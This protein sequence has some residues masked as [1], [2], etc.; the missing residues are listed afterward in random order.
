MLQKIRDNAHGWWTWLLVPILIILFAFWGIGNYLGGS[1][2]Q[3]EVAKVNGQSISAT[4]FMSM[5]QSLSNSNNPSQNPQLNQEIKIQVLQALVSKTLLAQALE[6]LGFAVDDPS[7]NQMIYHIPAFQ[8]NGQFSLQLYQAFLQNIGESTASLKTDLRQTYLINQFQN[9]LMMTGLVLPNEIMTETNYANMFRTVAYARV[10][11]SN[12]TSQTPITSAQVQAY[13]NAHQ[14]SFT[15]PLQVRLSYVTLSLSQ[16]S[17]KGVD[18]STAQANYSAALNQ[19]ANL[20]FQNSSSLT[21]LAQAFG[22]NVQTTS[23]Q[24][25]SKPTGILTNANVIAAVSSDSVLAQGNNSGVINLSPTQAVV[26]RVIS[27]IPSSPLPLVTVQKQIVAQ[28]K[29][30]ATTQNAMATLNSM[31]DAINQ[32]GSLAQVAPAYG[33]TVETMN[34]INPKSKVLPA[35]VINAALSMGVNQ[36]AAI[37]V[38]NGI[39]MVIEVTNVYPNPKAAKNPISAEALQGLW[40]Q[41]EL[42]QYL[43]YLQAQA[44]VNI[45]QALF[46]PS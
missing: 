24:D 4:E 25:T 2:S 21:P 39:V 35:A 6:K 3:D 41:I 30:Q 1:F 20:A 32:G 40:T 12:F 43:A 45:N 19:A 34:G 9:G 26:L 11:L 31:V 16:F 44:K 5:Y 29:Q 10:L 18:P 15:T 22:V 17:K 27:N 8:Q 38:A 13:Y 36:A 23:M 14:D 37:P 7:V 46:K 33:L 28:L 42:S